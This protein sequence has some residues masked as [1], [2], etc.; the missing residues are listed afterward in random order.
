MQKFKHYAKKCVSVVVMLA[1]VS[2]LFAVLCIPASAESSSWQ[3]S[4]LSDFFGDTRRSN[5]EFRWNRLA[6]EFY[7][8]LGSGIGYFYFSVDN[9]GIP[10]KYS[11]T[12]D[13]PCVYSFDS[14]QYYTL[15]FPLSFSTNFLNIN[16]ISLAVVDSHGDAYYFKKVN[17]IWPDP[18]G[19]ASGSG[20]QYSTTYFEA[21]FSGSFLVEVKSFRFTIGGNNYNG[22]GVCYG[23]LLQGNYVGITE[24]PKVE[25][26]SIYGDPNIDFNQPS[27]KP[28][29]DLHQIEQDLIDQG[30]LDNIGDFFSSEG[31]GGNSIVNVTNGLQAAGVLFSELFNNNGR[32][33]TIFSMLIN[34]SLTLG[35]VCLLINLAPKVFSGSSRSKDKGRKSNKGGKK[36]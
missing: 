22:S 30:S 32:R 16:N 4:D 6:N 14:S 34:F 26:E 11:F 5:F 28:Q 9:D 8:L 15:S 35:L 18:K 29:D 1:L 24:I 36:T 31:N 3:T 7:S 20:Q 10:S 19:V 13:L 21:T 25:Y 33:Y 12:V 23:G 17:Q 2:C 27:S